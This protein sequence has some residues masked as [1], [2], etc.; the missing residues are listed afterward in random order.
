L[1]TISCSSLKLI[2]LELFHSL[3]LISSF[4][5]CLNMSALTKSSTN[6]HMEV[7]LIQW[8]N[9][10]HSNC[11]SFRGDLPTFGSSIRR[12]YFLTIVLCLNSYMYLLFSFTKCVKENSTIARNS[13]SKTPSI[14]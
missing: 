5:L 1:S 12:E 10:F 2:F 6:R 8:V 7:L 3:L 14:T 9:S 13:L 4:I 11:N